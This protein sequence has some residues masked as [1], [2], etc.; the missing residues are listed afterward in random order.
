V[1]GQGK[2]EKLLHAHPCWPDSAKKRFWRAQALLSGCKQKKTKKRYTARAAGV[3]VTG[4]GRPAESDQTLLSPAESDQ[5]LLSPA[6]SDQ[7]AAASKKKKKYARPAEEMTGQKKCCAPCRRRP[8]K[9]S[10]RQTLLQ[11]TD[12]REQACAVRPGRDQFNRST[13]PVQPLLTRMVLVKT[14]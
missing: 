13:M 4:Q 8:E 11:L 1:T 14:G 2:V 9:K 7:K 6:E 12:L 5:T 3:E 10:A